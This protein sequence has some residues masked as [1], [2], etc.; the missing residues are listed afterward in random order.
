MMTYSDNMLLMK[1]TQIQLDEHKAEALRRL[2]AD[3]GVSVAELIRRAVDRVLAEGDHE[4]RVRRAL[5]VVGK[6]SS[7]VRDAGVEHD[8][9]LAEAFLE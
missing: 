3:R 6:F 2:A 4:E 5:A 8:R 9:E 1:R 7:G